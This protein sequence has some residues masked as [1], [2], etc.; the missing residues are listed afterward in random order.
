VS[1]APTVPPRG[2]GVSSPR[3]L[4]GTSGPPAIVFALPPD[5]DPGI[6]ADSRLIV[7]FSAYMDEDSFAGNVRLRYADGEDLPR[8]SWRYDDPRRALIVDP[9][10]PL[11]PGGTLE[12]LLLPGIVDVD[13]S[14]LAPRGGVSPEGVVEILRYGVGGS[15]SP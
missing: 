13:G 4:V 1:V 15:S 3:R 9:G 5:G 7:Q 11:R 12:L 2:A 14:A 10:E 6:A 8:M